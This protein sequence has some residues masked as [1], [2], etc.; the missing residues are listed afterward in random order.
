MPLSKLH[1]PALSNVISYP[2]YTLVFITIFY[3]IACSKEAILKFAIISRISW[4]GKVK[5]EL[6]IQIHELRVKT[7]ELRVENPRVGSLEA[8][9]G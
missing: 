5:H 6:R 2:L 4:R 3:Y 1:G 8:R 7:H 9:V